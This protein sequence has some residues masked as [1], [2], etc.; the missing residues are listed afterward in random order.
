MGS[1]YEKKKQ[2]SKIWCYCPFK[3]IKSTVTKKV[4]QKNSKFF[5]VTSAVIGGNSTPIGA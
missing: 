1:I 5:F 2:L 3:Y 4:Y